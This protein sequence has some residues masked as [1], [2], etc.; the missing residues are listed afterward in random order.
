M[1][2]RT[3]MA[4]SPTGNLHLG[5]AYATL[6]PY[7][8]AKKSEGKFLLRIEDT[9]RERSTNEFE[10]NIIN[11]LKWLKFSWDE[12]PFHQ[13]DRLNLYMEKTQQLLQEGKAYF[14][15]CSK[16]ELDEERK[17]QTESRLPQIYSGKCRNIPSGEAEKR[18]EGGEPYVI[19]HKLSEDRGVIEYE[20]LI[21]GKISFDSKLIGDTV[22]MRQSGIPLYNYAVVIDDIDMGI[23]HVIR[24]DD[25]ISNTPKQILLWEAFGKDLPSFAHYPVLLNQDRSG[26]LSKRTGST[27]VEEYKHMGYLPE[28]MINY[29]ALLGWTPPNNQ[30]VL[31][32]EEI[33]NVFDIKDMNNAAA[34]WNEQKLDW[35][36][37]EYIRKMSDEELTQRLEAYLVD[38]PRKEKIAPL[39]P[40]IKERIKKLSDFIPLTNFILEK[41]EYD[42]E[43]FK[44]LKID[45]PKVVLEKVLKNLEEM[46]KPWS[47]ENFEQTFKK[48]AEELEISNVDMFQLL[49]IAVSGQLVSPPLFESI[50]ILGEEETLKR[51][52]YVLETYPNFPFQKPEADRF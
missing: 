20:D 42:L 27:S 15:F 34:A 18:K 13:M 40:L 12:G 37:G 45:D 25:H 33:I 30:E 36:N 32:F 22:I 51:I 44:K 31:S 10:E 9:D 5:T 28:A 48:L 39:V 2:V 43:V 29:L 4:P 23:T 6:W 8:F 16:E 19:R 38:H 47:S 14:C 21:H 24:G 41:A 11:G 3:R 17:K 52:K 46:E 49:R 35:I 26:K 7:L 1:N 50:Q